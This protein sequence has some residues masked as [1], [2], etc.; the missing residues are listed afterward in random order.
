MKP[1]LSVIF[2]T[3]SSGAGLGLLVWLLV[4]SLMADHI[5]MDGVTFYKG[6]LIAGLLITA[7]LLSSTLHLA[8]RKNAIYALTRARTS[9]L[10]REGLLAVVLYPLAALHLAADRKS[11]V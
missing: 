7:G 3:V 2:F 10:S 4:A 6:V 5:R 1:A 8:N 11:V 9:W